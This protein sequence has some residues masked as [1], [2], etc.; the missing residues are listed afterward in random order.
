[1]IPYGGKLIN[2]TINEMFGT[3][4]G[5]SE[6]WKEDYLPADYLLGSKIFHSNFSLDQDPSVLSQGHVFSLAGKNK[7]GWSSGAYNKW[8]FLINCLQIEIIGIRCGGSGHTWLF[9]PQ[10]LGVTEHEWP[11]I[12]GV[13]LCRGHEIYAGIRN[14][15]GIKNHLLRLKIS[16]QKLQTILQPTLQPCQSSNTRNVYTSHVYQDQWWRR[17]A[18]LDVRAS[19]ITTL[20]V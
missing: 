2:A 6:I 17:G 18:I 4:M 15:A 11:L 12:L 8:H 3:E 1:V 13:R 19:F 9:I 20:Q 7:G 14:W 16:S 5:D 10:D